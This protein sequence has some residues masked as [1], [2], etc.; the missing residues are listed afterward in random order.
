MYVY[1]VI[2]KQI[3]IFNI[4]HVYFCQVFSIKTEFAGQLQTGNSY[5]YYKKRLYIRVGRFLTFLS[6]TLAG[7]WT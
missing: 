5:F 2:D 6:E 4:L 3:D 7:T 1:I